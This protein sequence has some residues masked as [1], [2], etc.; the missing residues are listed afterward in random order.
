MQA[1]AG[2]AV[3]TAA[4]TAKQRSSRISSRSRQQKHNLQRGA[5]AHY[6]VLRGIFPGKKQKCLP[7]ATQ[8]V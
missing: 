5:S 3:K 6:H 8:G 2:T 4:Q 7:N 1:A